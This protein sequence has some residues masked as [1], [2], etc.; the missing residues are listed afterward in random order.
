MK[1]IGVW[2]SKGDRQESRIGQ[3]WVGI[4][5]GWWDWLWESEAIG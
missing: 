1:L 3:V 2:G 5:W 4:E